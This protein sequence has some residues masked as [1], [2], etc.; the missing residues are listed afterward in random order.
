MNKVTKA[1]EEALQ[2]YLDQNNTSDELVQ[3]LKTLHKLKNNVG[4][5]VSKIL[6]DLKVV[7]SLF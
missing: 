2:N 3:N 7:R 1:L 6:K 5:R 4:D